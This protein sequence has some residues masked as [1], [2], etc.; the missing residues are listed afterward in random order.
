VKGRRCVTDDCT[1][2]DLRRDFLQGFLLMRLDVEVPT[3]AGKTGPL[4]RLGL[5]V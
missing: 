5:A 1:A 3:R 4:K 2:I